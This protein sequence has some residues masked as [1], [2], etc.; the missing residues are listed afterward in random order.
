M[1]RIA[2]IPFSDIAVIQRLLGNSP[3]VD[4]KLIHVSYDPER[5]TIYLHLEHP[6]FEE[7]PEASV[8]PIECMMDGLE[9][10]QIRK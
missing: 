6:F 7:I 4:A 8:P 9:K 5:R 10:F 2:Q 3:L 1:R